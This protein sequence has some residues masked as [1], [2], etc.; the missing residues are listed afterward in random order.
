M[1]TFLLT[2]STSWDIDRLNYSSKSF[3]VSTQDTVPRSVFLKDDGLTM[4]VLGDTNDTVYQYTLS[5]AWDVSSASYASKSKLISA[6]E[7][8]AYGMT[9][10]NNGASMYICGNANKTVYQYTL[11]TPWDVST[12][13]YASK[14]KL[15]ST[16]EANPAYIFFKPDGLSMY[17]TGA[18]SD[19]TNQYTLSTA[20]D[21]STASYASKAA[22]LSGSGDTLMVGGF[23]DPSG[24]RLFAVGQ[25]TT[26]SV[27]Q[28]VLSTPWDASTSSYTNKSFSVSSE[29][30]TPWNIFYRY[31]GHKM[32]LVGATSQRIFQYD[33]T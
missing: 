29:D 25:G 5:I 31:D 6:E 3:D 12:A 14:S 10:R 13:S 18:G 9:F 7:T 23:F 4:Y 22:D 26:D 19:K 11:S 21:V 30:T 16:E 27:Y 17:V 20:W 33:A 1:F 28:Y 32:Y 2:N 8:Q 24:S 15:V